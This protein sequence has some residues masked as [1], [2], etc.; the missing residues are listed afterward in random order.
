MTV[1]GREVPFTVGRQVEATVVR[2]D[3]PAADR[4]DA[5]VEY[6]AG[7]S[8]IAPTWET[9]VGDRDAGLKIVGMR[10][11]GS[12]VEFDLEGIAGRTYTLGVTGADRV[13][14]MEGA[15]L[16]ENTLRVTF[17]E[18]PAGSFTA[19]TVRARTR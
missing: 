4:L 5:L 12:D 17:P 10:E 1:D 14:R 11:R 19:L 13:Q 9:R 8:L 15:G 7:F 3:A 2:F 6:D 16:E 18:G